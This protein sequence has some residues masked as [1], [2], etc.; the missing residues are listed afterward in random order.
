MSGLRKGRNRDGVLQRAF[1]RVEEVLF[2][3]S[4]FAFDFMK[5]YP[6][7]MMYLGIFYLRIKALP[8]YSRKAGSKSKQNK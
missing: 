3:F 8:F 4:F 2:P 1:L 5:D 7:S 6:S